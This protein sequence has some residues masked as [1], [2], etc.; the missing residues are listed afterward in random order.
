MIRR[1]RR[2]FL[3]LIFNENYLRE[4]MGFESHE[5]IGSVAGDQGI[6]VSHP[7]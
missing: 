7:R 3:F 4:T 2:K 1:I 5:I 6:L